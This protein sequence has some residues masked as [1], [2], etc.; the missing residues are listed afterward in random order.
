MFIITAKRWF[1]KSYGNTYHSVT[2]RENLF[3]AYQKN[4][5][6]YNK[7]VGRISFRYGYGD[8]YLN[9]AADIMGISETELRDDIRENRQNYHITVI[10]VNGKNRSF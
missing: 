10:D 9:T 2:I 4:D 8:H 7:E 3:N 1:Q 5:I 6:I